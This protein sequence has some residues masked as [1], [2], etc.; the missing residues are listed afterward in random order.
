MRSYAHISRMLTP[1][2]PYSPHTRSMS[3]VLVAV[4]NNDASAG[5]ARVQLV[6]DGFPTDRVDLVSLQELGQAKLVPRATVGEQ[7]GEYFRKVLQIS[8]GENA[9]SVQVLQRAVLDGSAAVIVQPRGEAEIARAAQ[10]LNNCDP[11]EMGGTDLANTTLEHASAEKETPIT[12]IGKV[13]AAAGAPDT[14]G[15][16]KLP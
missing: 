7:L 12:W 3:A 9:Q 8:T 11:V 6:N 5:A 15:T 16:P 4:F 13:L 1:S 10:L 2:R 14:T